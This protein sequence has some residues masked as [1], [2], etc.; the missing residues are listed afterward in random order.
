VIAWVNTLPDPPWNHEKQDQPARHFPAIGVYDGHGIEHG[1]VL[2]DSTWHHWFDMNL[3]QLEAA[4]NSDFRKIRR[5]FQNVAI[6]LAPRAK[7]RQMFR[8][9]TFWTVLQPEALEELS[10]DTAFFRLGGN[11]IDI[12]G[13]STSDCLVIDWLIDLLPVELIRAVREF[14]EPDPCWS[15]PPIDLLSRFVL[16]GMVHEMLPLREE[17]VRQSWGKVRDRVDF[18]PKRIDEAMEA[19]MKA[20]FRALAESVSRN[21]KALSEF[22]RQAVRALG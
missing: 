8:F 9:A 12:L 22:E 10:R 7:Q 20:G 11:A 5:Y 19:G 17:L 18:N 1:R 21:A 2:V 16:G 13:R 4:D 15:C 14:P 6:W 3:A